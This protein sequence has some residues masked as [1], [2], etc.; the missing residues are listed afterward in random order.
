MDIGRELASMRARL[1]RLENSARLS[2]ASI[3]NTA[4]QVR[5]GDGSLRG[6]LGVQADGTTAVNIVNGPPPPQPS[7]PI[8]TGMINGVTVSWDGQFADGAVVPLDWQRT[9]VHVSPLASYT[10]GADTL[11]ATIETAQGAT[12]VVACDEPVYVLLVARNTSGTASTPS[13][14]V[15]PTEPTP[16]V[17][18]DV[19]D[20]IITTVKLAD[21]AV[22]QAKVAVGAIGTTEISDNAITTPKIVAAA[23]QAAQI[24]TDAVNASKIAAGAVTTAKLDALA[25]TSDKL[26]ANSVIAGKVAA[27]AISTNQLTVGIADSISQKITDAMGDATLWTQPTDTGAW[28]VVTGVTDAGAGSTVIQATGRTTLER[29]TNTP[30]DPDALYKVTARIRTTVTPVSGTPTVYIGL[31]GIAADGTTRVN[32]T[33][34]NL[35]ANQHYIAAANL[36]VSVGTTWTTVTGYAKGTAATGTITACPDPK[37][38]GQLHTSVRYIRPLVR[39][40]IGSTSGGTMQVDQVTLETVPTGVVNAVNIADGAITAAKISAGAVDATALAA[41]AI[42]GKT[43]TGGTITGSLLQTAASGARITI[44]ESAANKVLVYDGVISTAIGELSERGLLVQGTTGAVLWL[45][46]DATYP[47]LR[48]TNAAQTNSAVINVS[49]NTAGAADLGMNSGT[50]TGSGYTDMKWRT[51]MGND[52]AVIERIRS[53]TGLPIGGRIDL[54]SGYGSVSYINADNSSQNN[55]FIVEAGRGQLTNG[56]LEVYPPASSNAALYVNTATGHTGTLLNLLVNSVSKFSVDKDGNLTVA[57]TGGF[58]SK[59]RSTD[60][61]RTNTTTPTNDTQITF[62]VDANAIYE[63]DGWLKYSGPGDFQMGWSTPSGAAGEWMGLGNG[64]TVVSGTASN[65]TQQDVTSPWGYTVRTETTDI[66]A[67]RVYGG[68]ST[69]AYGVIVRGTLRVSS[70]GGTF[71]L[72]WAQ[73]GAN[74]T[75][76]TLYTDSRIRLTKVA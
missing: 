75:A 1:E 27:G 2:H 40:L 46:P 17:A 9:E 19:V 21:D 7:D 74:A 73:G 24:D 49:E 30:F 55:I 63:I 34:A 26:A 64:T 57:G 10:P 70:T 58:Q 72:R 12:A 76:T 6:L 43:I 54:R 42:T 69:N 39:L 3:D 44:N 32:Q 15:G 45:D 47:N 31:T 22:T 5:D 52:F 56:R 65:G 16:V 13:R 28:A 67:T 66:A 50:F 53:S 29:T 23:V 48:M 33:G 20:G 41:D 71:A 61:T 37:A 35:I 11:K 60:D 8:V 62:T 68:V 36:T 4:V 14:I 38:P 25:V 18:D 51:F 59:R